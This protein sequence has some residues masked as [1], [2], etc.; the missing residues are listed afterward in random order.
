MA[1][2]GAFACVCN[3]PTCAKC[4]E[5]DAKWAGDVLAA[6]KR[7]PLRIGVEALA[8]KSFNWDRQESVGQSK[9]RVVSC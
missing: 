5:L 8:M 2:I 6:R 4:A 3:K 7:A 1:N 9:A